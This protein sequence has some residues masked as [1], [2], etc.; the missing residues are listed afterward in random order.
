MPALMVAA[1]ARE[2]EDDL[3]EGDPG[4]LRVPSKAPFATGDRDGGSE[5]RSGAIIL[6]ARRSWWLNLSQVKHKPL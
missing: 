4:G 5:L 3:G 1:A 6:R 2:T